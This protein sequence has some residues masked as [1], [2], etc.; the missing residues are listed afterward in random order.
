[1]LIIEVIMQETAG[2]FDVTVGVEGEFS[3][4]T[5]IDQRFDQMVHLILFLF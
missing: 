5:V 1:L 3:N 4:V 2:E